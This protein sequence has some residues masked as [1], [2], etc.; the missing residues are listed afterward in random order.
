MINL[1][2]LPQTMASMHYVDDS[3]AAPIIYMHEETKEEHKE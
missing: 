2:T 3:E 1:N